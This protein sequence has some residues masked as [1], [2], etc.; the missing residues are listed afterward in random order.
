M[1]RGIDDMEKAGKIVK[2]IGATAVTAFVAGVG[3]VAK[4][5]VEYFK[6]LKNQNIILDLLNSKKDELHAIKSKPFKNKHDK[7][8]INE[9]TKDISD[10]MSKR[11]R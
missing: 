2:G 9:L 10:L 3:F 11:K 6:D 4:H 5:G 8:K 1:A 7:A